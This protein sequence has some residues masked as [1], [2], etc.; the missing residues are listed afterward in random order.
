MFLKLFLLSCGE[1][2]E[3]L[4]NRP[5]FKLVFFNQ[6]SESPGGKEER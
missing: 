3:L 4:T 1:A 5:L 6:L 2:L